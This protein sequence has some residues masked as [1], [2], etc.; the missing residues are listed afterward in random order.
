MTLAKSYRTYRSGPGCVSDVNRLLFDD[1][2]ESRW[3]LSTTQ[4]TCHI[5]NANQ[6]EVTRR[7]LPLV[8]LLQLFY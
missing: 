1:H 7:R 5:F 3:L 8:R 2:V 4:Q 6:T